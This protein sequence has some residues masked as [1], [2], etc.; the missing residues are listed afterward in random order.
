MLGL[1]EIRTFYPDTLHRFPRFLLREYL[2]YKLLE[3]I[4]TSPYANQLC[5]LGG[6]CLRIVYGN[7]RFSEDLDFDNMSLKPDQFKEI[8]NEIQKGLTREGYAVEIKQIMRRA[9]HCYIRFP[10]LLYQEGLSGYQEEKILVQL[11]TEPQEYEYE[12][13]EFILNKFEVFTTI[14]TTPPSLLFAQKLFAIL[15]RP[16]KQ[17]RD[18]F[19]VVYL[20]GKNIKP[21]FNYLKIKTNIS[22]PTHLKNA[23]LD[24]CDDLDMKKL[25]AD[26]E[27]FL[28]ESTAREKVVKFPEYFRQSF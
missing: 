5:F 8:T 23:I 3:I 10:G 15:N 7:Q 27:P 11:D 20:M 4:Y 26:V 12:P 13:E 22:N 24:I 19:D 6:T 21:D 18:F 16:R 9:W 28:F 25:A 14:K 17:G 1:D 2:Q